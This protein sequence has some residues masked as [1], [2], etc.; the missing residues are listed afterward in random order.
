MVTE[1]QEEDETIQRERGLKV[2]AKGTARC[3]AGKT[4]ER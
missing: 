2:K 1:A 3:E 4:F